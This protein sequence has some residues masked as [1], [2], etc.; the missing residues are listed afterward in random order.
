MKTLSIM[1]LL[2]FFSFS[3]LLAQKTITGTV[4]DES[5][6]AV[7]GA[8]VVEKGTT[9]GASTD[10]DGKYSI[11]VAES[12]TTLVFSYVGFASQEVEISGNTVDVTMKEGIDMEKVVVT[13]L[14]VTKKEKSLG[15][16]SQEVSGDALDQN[17]DANFLNTLQG[18]VAGVQIT[19]SSNLGGSSRILIRGASSITGENQPLFVVDGTPMNNSNF[20]SYN[21]AR[22]AGGYD[23]GNAISDIN[24]DDI[25]SINVLK[26]AAATALYGDR[27]ANGVVMITTKKGMKSKKGKSP[28]GVS[29]NSSIQ[30]NE[31]AVLPTYQNK[32]GG[33]AGNVFG[34]STI[35]TNQLVADF[36]Y[37][38]SWGPKFDGQQVRQWDSY[39][40]WDVDNY[41]QTREW[42]ASPNDLSS[43]FQTGILA[44]NNIA[45]NGANDK[46]G[47][48]VSYTNTHQ[49]GTQVNSKLNRHNVSVN[50]NYN[51]TDKLSATASLN[52]VSMEGNGRPITG[53]GESIMSQ[54]TQWGQMQLDFNRLQNY[55]NP[56]GTQRTWNRNSETD[57]SPHYWDNPYW[58]RYENGQEDRRER[59]FG[60]IGLA[61]QITDFLSVSAR[62]MTDFYTDRRKEWVAVGGV[63]VPKYSEDV[64][65]TREDNYDARINFEK[66][67]SDL[68][69]VNAITGI[70]FRSN[71]Y[72]SN[73]T[74]T[75]GGLN[76]PGFYSLENSVSPA[77][78]T[79]YTEEQEI[80][81]YYF[82]ASV[83]IKDFLYVDGNF[84]YD[85]NSTLPTGN[86]GIPY[87]GVGLSF[88]FSELLPQND[89]LSFGKLRAS[90]AVSGKGT[91]PYSLYASYTTNTSFGNNGMS[92]VPNSLNNANLRP[93]ITTGIETGL[94]LRFFNGRLNID[95]TYYNQV[96]NDL[97]Y[98][99]SQS[100]AAGYS[101]RYLNA[102]KVLNHGV[103]IMATGTA[104]KTSG[105][106]WDIGFNFAKNMNTV[107]ELYEGVEN[108]R[109]ASLFGPTL[110]A[111]VG[112]PIHSFY[113]NNF[114]YDENGNKLVDN[115]GAYVSNGDIQNLGSVLADFTGGVSTTLSY[116]GISLYLLFDFQSGGRVFSLS[117]QWGK[118][119][120][121]LAETAEGNIREDG[122]IVDGV[123]ATQDANGNWITDGTPN[124]VTI[125]AQSHFFYNQGY[126][127]NAADI[128]DASFVKFRE[129]RIGYTFPNSMLEKT[130]FRDLSISVVARNLAILHKN[131]PNIDPEAAVNAGNIQ[132][133]EGGQL[134]TERSIGVNLKLKF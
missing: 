43:F 24:P 48:R 105:F 8:S 6:T 45:F 2:L 90:Y 120:G 7:I 123:K 92:T 84:R 33:G 12:A 101:S 74:S 104:V 91:D 70:N 51:L 118:Y 46:G 127:I 108:V 22:G 107:L 109:I 11:S 44:T 62:G 67:F 29:I 3:S 31:V 68:I 25:E 128:Y 114:V 18:K 134:P 32:Y 52:V 85:I 28:I 21:Q 56:D 125:D 94:D 83:A 9:N 96:T 76:T 121:T 72:H 47:F 64:R 26:G 40:E 37:D 112:Q 63:R 116:K 78:I 95:A 59:I 69:S 57:P 113:G 5:G 41:G 87:G 80:F 110:E 20:T 99:V 61:Y 73:L 106:R 102:G 82:N 89:I 50:G 35:D 27:G 88:V 34:N 53:Y 100:S 122:I 66:R 60:N 16:S 4:T 30:F 133:F 10:L 117:N 65:F 81:S 58:E 77:D 54:F 49:I 111:R 130:P 98:A 13:A 86:N 39:D 75:Q 115:T 23:Y 131:A 103:E 71:T 124:D 15:Y 119:S 129:A 38:G 93:E 55:K 97:I 19:G 126:I 36:G 42:K 14:G 79:D 1:F 17:R 132:G